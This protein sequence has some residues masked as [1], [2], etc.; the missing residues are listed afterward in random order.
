MKSLFILC[1]TCCFLAILK[2]PIEYY[3]FLRII[4]S[5]GA[6]V[7]IYQLIK[8]KK[9][10]WIIAFTAILIFFNP[11]FL[12]YLHRKSIW[13]PFDIAAGLLFLLLIFLKEKKLIKEEIE[14][15]TKEKIYTRDRIILT[16]NLTKK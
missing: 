14:S 1:S 4:V 7:A 9:Y 8:H 6:V 16:K 2:L 12:I 13:L 3:T 11:V 5:I 10:E 15:L